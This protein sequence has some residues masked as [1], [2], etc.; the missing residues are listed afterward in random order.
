[1]SCILSLA[2]CHWCSCRDSKLTYVVVDPV[3]TLVLRPH[4]REVYFKCSAYFWKP[5]TTF[6]I[7]SNSVVSSNYHSLLVSRW[8]C[9]NMYSFYLS[10]NQGVKFM[11]D[12][13]TGKQIE[14][15]T[16]CIMADE[17]VK[18]SYQLNP[19]RFWK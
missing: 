17:M 15:S 7:K 14:G 19:H 11:Y 1:M 9:L 2:V 16:G 12:C 18:H 8:K 6:R 4:Q 13:V 5:K 10:A 3:L